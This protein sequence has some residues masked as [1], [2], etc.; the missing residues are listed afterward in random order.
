MGL[1]GALARVTS[2][3]IARSVSRADPVVL[4]RLLCE[5]ESE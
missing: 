5:K 4:S 3:Q 2:L 1:L